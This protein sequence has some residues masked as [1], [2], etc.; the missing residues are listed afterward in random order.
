MKRVAAALFLVVAAAAAAQQSKSQAVA[1]YVET[2]DVQVNNVDVIVTDRSGRHVP[3]L[4]QEDF[5]VLEDGRPQAI[6]NF[7]EYRRTGGT[8]SAAADKASPAADTAHVSRKLVFII[9]ELSLH[10]VTRRTMREQLR[11]FIGSAMREGD[12]AMIVTPEARLSQVRLRFTADREAILVELERVMDESRFRANTALTREELI[13]EQ[14]QTNETLGIRALPSYYDDMVKR[15][16]EK[17]FAHLQSI[18]SALAEVPGKKSVVLVTESLPAFA[19]RGLTPTQ[20]MH[21]N[22]L[23]N[24]LLRWQRDLYDL[25]PM[26]GDIATTASTNGIA[27]YCLQPE[28]GFSYAAPGSDIAHRGGLGA[29]SPSYARFHDNLY[30]TEV[31]MNIL[32]DRTGGKWQRGESRVDDFFDQVESDLSAYYSIGYHPGEAKR[33]QARRIEVKVRNH[34][35]LR[36]RARQ[37]V[38]QKSPGEEMN[39]L[40][41]AS[42]VY[43]KSVDE[44]GIAATAG[45]PRREGRWW[46]VPIDVRVPIAKL[47][48]LPAGD[49]YRG[50]F[51]VHYAAAAEHGDFSGGVEREQVVEVPAAEMARTNEQFFTYTA[52]LKVPQGR[53]NIAV[54]V[55]DPV[56]RLSSFKQMEVVAR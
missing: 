9:D 25:R 41:V 42:L 35:G 29:V 56:S 43:P 46:I 50:S 14:E 11:E 4:R 6:T 54:G 49:K 27:I 53:V 23:D 33:D 34:P 17:T 16:V 5:V 24:M 31:T 15:R 22:D 26:I 51:S 52:K 28:Y 39:E 12:E 55:L 7:S 21:S 47:T 48:L 10:P 36:V 32:A 3:G 19:G 44:L 13:T 45:E 2:F 1:P 30:N 40:V 8:A 18:V 20:F 38:I 37:D